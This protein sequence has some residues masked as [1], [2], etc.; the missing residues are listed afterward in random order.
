MA[1]LLR[2]AN[3][4]TS[5]HKSIDL[6][7]APQTNSSFTN[8]EVIQHDPVTKGATNHKFLISSVGAEYLYLALAKVFVAIRIVSD[9]GADLPPE[10]KVLPVN[11]IFS[12]FSQVDVEYNSK[13]M[14]DQ[15]KNHPYA[16]IFDV[17]FNYDPDGEAGTLESMGFYKDTAYFHNSLVGLDN[18]PTN[19]GNKQ[20]WDNTKGSQRYE[21]EGP[22]GVD[23]LTC[24]RML[25]NGMNLKLTFHHTLPAFYLLAE[26]PTKKYKVVIEDMYLKIPH[27]NV[28]SAILLGHDAALKASPALYPFDKKEFTGH[29]IDK[30]ALKSTAQNIFQGKLPN[31]LVIALINDLAYSGDLSLNPFEFGHFG[32]SHIDLRVNSQLFN[33][34]AI[35]L[36]VSDPKNIKCLEAYDDML[37][38]LRK[39]EHANG[40]I[41]NRTDYCGGYTFFIYDFEHGFANSANYPVFEKGGINV[42]FNFHSTRSHAVQAL[43]C[44]YYRVMYGVDHSR[45]IIFP[46]DASRSV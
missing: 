33:S 34:R 29:L 5:I 38:A 2:L 20:R 37:N 27:V 15:T 23:V 4:G 25:L 16:N 40:T 26:D 41:I 22:I 8:Y 21:M 31:L 14:V 46:G 45:R 12:L 32:L 3:S 6:F 44:G 18:I 7:T 42:D 24:E 30:N 13:L 1:T 11:G 17:L 39:W 28:N 36:N 19:T 35:E 9:T 43:F 10:E